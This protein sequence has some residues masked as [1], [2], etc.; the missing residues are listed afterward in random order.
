MTA[1]G[2]RPRPDPPGAEIGALTEVGT[3][4]SVPHRRSTAASEVADPLDDGTTLRW[5]S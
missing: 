5:P 3:F 2:Y 1:A 4:E